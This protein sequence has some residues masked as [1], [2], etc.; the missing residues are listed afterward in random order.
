MPWV[1]KS[2]L[3][4]SLG[5]QLIRDG[6]PV[7]Y[8]SIFGCGRDFLHDETFQGNNKVLQRYLRPD[9]LIL[10]ILIHAKDR[11]FFK[12]TE[13][14]LKPAFNAETGA[15]QLDNTHW[16]IPKQVQIVCTID[17]RRSVADFQFGI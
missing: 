8:R 11:R 6:F 16:H 12:T 7:Y 1:G 10:A 13:D 14:P 5:R 9:L 3:L 2:Y 4:Q 17:C 15:A